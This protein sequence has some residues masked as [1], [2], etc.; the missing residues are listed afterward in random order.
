V[1]GRSATGIYPST[2]NANANLKAFF[3]DYLTHTIDASG[4][5]FVSSMEALLYPIYMIAFHPG[6][7]TE[8]G[9]G[10]RC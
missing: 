7:T 9:E 10:K 8:G 6:E 2:W 3:G 1:A 5:A 4:T